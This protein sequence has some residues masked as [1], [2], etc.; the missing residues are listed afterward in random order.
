MRLEGKNVFITGGTGGIGKPLVRLMQDAGARV[1]VYDRKTQGDLSD[2]LDAACAA[3][4]LEAP[5]ILINLAGYN[6]FSHCEHQAAE[7]VIRINLTV[8][9]RLT[10]AV[11]PAMRKRGSGQ[12]V[13]IGSMT[14][15]IPL[16]HLTC[17]VA[18]KAG[19][20]GF[21]DALR[22]EV[23]GTG[24]GITH[25]TPRAVSTDANKG[26]KKTLNE[27]TGVN[28]DSAEK[29][30]LRILRAIERDEMDVR[31]G[32][33]ERFFAF[34][35]ALFPRLIDRGLRR[36]R[37]IGEEILRQNSSLPAAKT[38]RNTAMRNIAIFTALMI[39]AGPAMA[40]GLEAGQ[41]LAP[42]V[43]HMPPLTIMPDTMQ[44]AAVEDPV[45]LQVADLQTE[46]AEIKYH[47]TDTDTQISQMSALGERA[48]KLAAAYPERPEPKIW[49]AIILSSEAGLVKGI[50]ALP[51]VKKAK[52]LL[53]ESARIDIQALQGSAYTSLGS[54]YYQVPGW[55]V[56]FGDSAKAGEYLKAALKINPDGIDPNYF[57]GDYL[58]HEERFAEAIPVLEKALAAPD[59]PGRELADAGRRQEIRSALAEARRKA[60]QGPAGDAKY[61]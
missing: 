59:R 23:D 18:A 56:A 57:Y 6:D 47:G 5:D 50:S 48:G 12:I 40:Q 20:R 13:N 11:L 19:L 3:L 53:E 43:Q 58:M 29:V 44:E 33:P 16:P 15:L 49:Q 30:A 22:R 36:N 38:E 31:I 51:K 9:V 24:I 46:W 7:E 1:T 28:H 25:V 8:P 45:M 42:A 41:P 26:L 14:A 27:R 34:L 55:P 37:D 17:Y 52:A 4:S 60:G 2:R 54:L 21:S 39:A 10:Q 61:N 35:N 32:W